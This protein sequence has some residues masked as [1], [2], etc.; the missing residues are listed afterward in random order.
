MLLSDV[1]VWGS[2]AKR[3]ILEAL[4][5][6]QQSFT[7]YLTAS[8]LALPMMIT[9]I[10]TALLTLAVADGRGADG[11]GDDGRGGGDG[12]GGRG[13]GHGGMPSSITPVHH[14]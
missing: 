12:H 13:D 5:E 9:V 11:G 2:S 8:M 7:A 4:P 1:C 3:F 10:I 6:L 14:K